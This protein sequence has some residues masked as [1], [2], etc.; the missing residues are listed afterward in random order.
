MKMLEYCLVDNLKDRNVID[1]N[2]HQ[3]QKNSL[4]I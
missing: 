3:F 4:A 2:K 1:K